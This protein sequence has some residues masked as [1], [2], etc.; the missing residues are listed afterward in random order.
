MWQSHKIKRDNSTGKLKD[1]CGSP[2]VEI[3]GDIHPEERKHGSE[4][5]KIA[6]VANKYKWNS[7][8]NKRE[9]NQGQTGKQVIESWNLKRL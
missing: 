9:T 2:H 1:M 8:T 4:S 3:G 6:I 5:K 7:P